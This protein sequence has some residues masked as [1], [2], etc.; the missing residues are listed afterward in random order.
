MGEPFLL[1]VNDFYDR[2][3][4]DVSQEV[5]ESRLN[6]FAA[7]GAKTV[8]LLL[9]WHE[10][11]PEIRQVPDSVLR[12]L[13]SYLEMAKGSGLHVVPVFFCGRLGETIWLPHW[14]CETPQL[15]PRPLDFYRER[16]LIRAQQL[17]IEVVSGAFA[18]HENVLAW[19]LGRETSTLL[20]ATNP[21]AA[22]SRILWL[23]EALKRQ[24][25]AHGATLTLS[26]IDWEGYREMRPALLAEELDFLS[27]RVAPGDE[28]KVVLAEDIAGFYGALTRA[29][30][31]K[32]VLVSE[33]VVEDG[34]GASEQFETLL[35]DAHQ[36]GALG[37]IAWSDEGTL[38]NWAEESFCRFAVSRPRR[39]DV[40]CRLRVDEPSYY[41]D[42]DAGLRS[43]YDQFQ[44]EKRSMKKPHHPGL[45]GP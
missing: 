3:L 23:L 24:D 15:D 31:G 28:S 41:A 42:P 38:S 43:A 30:T 32:P 36:S 12:W 40:P 45:L 34:E 26:Q 37:V 33:W 19:D 4:Q 1:G 14:I 6:H 17:Q 27:L 20:P 16:D 29:L 11:Q 35:E 13:E 21:D 39:A 9:P 25:E 18:E 10:I 7:L 44:K 5:V 8:R 22:R 2:R